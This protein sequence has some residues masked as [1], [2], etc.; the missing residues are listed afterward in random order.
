MK[1]TLERVA[2][3]LREQ[4]LEEHV[5]TVLDALTKKPPQSANAA[6]Q[7]R[8]RE[9]RDARA[10]V[11]K[12]V[13]MT[14]LRNAPASEPSVTKGVTMTPKVTPLARVEDNP[15]TTEL[16]GKEDKILGAER[17]KTPR[18]I[19]LECL[20]PETADGVLAHRKAMRRP[21]T[22]R[23][24]QLL[25]K[26]FLA[27]ADPNAAADMMIER[28]WQGFKP[29]WFD[30]ERRSNGQHQRS[31]K[32]SIVEAGRRLTERLVAAE[33]LHEMQA[34][35]GFSESDDAVRLLPG[36]LRKRP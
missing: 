6:R 10:S 17:L 35:R 15:S 24:A 5:G 32:G 11:T 26:G 13:T 14:P 25:A 7:A 27:T 28:G 19:L 16:S 3:V 12:G 20:S 22:G 30:N 34:E 29:E 33:R 8:Y 2:A 4:G 36:G 31:G 9:R 18:E 23:A 21:L 1:L